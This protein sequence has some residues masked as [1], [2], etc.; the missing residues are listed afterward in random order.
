[1]HPQFVGAESQA[2]NWKKIKEILSE[3]I[4]RKCASQTRVIFVEMSKTRVNLTDISESH[5]EKISNTENGAEFEVDIKSVLLLA[6][7]HPTLLGKLPHFFI[8]DLS[9]A[10]V[11]SSDT[12]EVKFPYTKTSKQL[13]GMCRLISHLQKSLAENISF[14]QGLMGDI[15][16]IKKE[17]SLSSQIYDDMIVFILNVKKEINGQIIKDTV[18]E[19]VGKCKAKKLT[20]NI[21]LQESLALLLLFSFG[22]FWDYSTCLYQTDKNRESNM[23]LLRSDD[24]FRTYMQTLL[25]EVQQIIF[26]VVVAEKGSDMLFGSYSILNELSTLPV[27]PKDQQITLSTPIGLVFKTIELYLPFKLNSLHDLFEDQMFCYFY[28]LF[29]QAID[30]MVRDYRVTLASVAQSVYLQVIERFDKY[31]FTNGHPVNFEAAD[32]DTLKATYFRPIKV[33]LYLLENCRKKIGTADLQKLAYDCIAGSTKLLFECSQMLPDQIDSCLFIVKNLMSL[34]VFLQTSFDREGSTIKLNQLNYNPR[35][36]GINNLLAGRI[37]F[38]TI[39]GVLYDLMPRMTEYKVDLR[40]SVRQPIEHILDRILSQCVIQSTS[41]IQ[42]VTARISPLIKLITDLE[43][44][45]IG[46]SKNLNQESP[47]QNAELMKARAER[48]QIANQRE[49]QDA[50]TAFDDLSKAFIKSLLGKVNRYADDNSS[51]LLKSELIPYLENTLSSNLKSF[52]KSLDLPDR[53]DQW[54]KDV[55]ALDTTN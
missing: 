39:S 14:V 53:S 32:L 51:K 8:G 2:A 12:L 28:S 38:A 34:Y 36:H 19:L 4:I 6:C 18:Q 29:K 23:L 1:M 13:G 50:L 15:T 3:A 30:C 55:R 40:T 9:L 25:L 44:T 20:L 47:K 11:L 17:G 35:P 22:E 24:R 52:T 54:L 41:K 43:G 49:V 48:S 5:I 42:E 46:S 10:Q 37:D 7:L 45:E 27:I 33:T 21:F 26:P 16:R 31:S